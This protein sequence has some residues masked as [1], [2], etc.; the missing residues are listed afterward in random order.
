[1]NWQQQQRCGWGRVR[2]E[3]SVLGE[4]GFYQSSVCNVIEPGPWMQ[5]DKA[6]RVGFG[7]VISSVGSLLLPSLCRDKVAKV[8]STHPDSHASTPSPDF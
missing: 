3:N 5:Q 2:E 8:D 7:G 1:M 4:E 6:Y